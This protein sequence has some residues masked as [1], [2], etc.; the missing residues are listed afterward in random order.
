MTRILLDTD[1]GSDVDDALCLLLALATPGIELVGVTTVAA[2]AALRARITR[3][4]LELA[5]RAEIP[6][7]AGESAPISAENKFFLHGQEGQG[8]FPDGSDGSEIALP[9][10]DGIEAMAALLRAHPDAEV[11]AIGPMT[12]L[13]RLL[14]RFPE[15]AA[16]IPRLTIMGGHLRPIRFGDRM[17]PFGVDYNICSDP[18]ASTRVLA[19]GIPTRLV[20]ADVTLRTW[21][22]RDDRKRLGASSHPAVEATLRA[23]DLW[24]PVQASLF[25]EFTDLSDNVAFL[26]DPLALACV[27]DESF[28]RFEEIGVTTAWQDGVFRTL[29]EAAAPV[30][31]C[32]LEVDGPR[33]AGHFVERL[34]AL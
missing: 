26:H 15:E 4:L 16:R 33:F 30:M 6:V 14:E 1:M 18:E 28:C 20:T 25:S 11:V 24:S 32:A 10:G 13:A 5:G 2:D 23:L 12:N 9:D 19:S 29:E 34:L 22:S 27:L 21:L 8:I 3:R 31:R 7:H 17:F